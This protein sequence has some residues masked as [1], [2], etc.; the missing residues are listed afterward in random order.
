MLS[1][2]GVLLPLAV[3]VAVSSVP[4]MVTILML[5]SPKRKQVSVPFLIGW[6]IGLA[7]VVVAAALGAAAAMPVHT[8]RKEQTAIGIGEIAVGVVILVLAGV[9]W[10]RAR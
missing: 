6:V 4:I 3:A 9:A 2:L 10:R 5:L 8:S 7:G 1:A